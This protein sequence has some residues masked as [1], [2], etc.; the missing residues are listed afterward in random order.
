ML[1]IIFQ[2]QDNYTPPAPI[3]APVVNFSMDTQ[4]ARPQGLTSQET[5]Q[6]PPGAPKEGNFQVCSQVNVCGFVLAVEWCLD[7][8]ID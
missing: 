7:L 5:S 2:L 8:I 6:G 1:F 4:K 3:T